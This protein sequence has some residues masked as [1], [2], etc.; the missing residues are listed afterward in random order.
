M[1][2]GLKTAKSVNPIDMKSSHGAL[3]LWNMQKCLM[4]DGLKTAKS[5]NPIGMKSS[6]GALILWNMQK[7]L[8]IDGLK[9]AKSVKICIMCV[10]LSYNIYRLKAVGLTVSE[11]NFGITI[12]MNIVK[13]RSISRKNWIFCQ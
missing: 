6:H 7:C 5:V 4:I 3:I 9:T 11:N 2:D 8:M 12:F 1:I 13:F 10:I